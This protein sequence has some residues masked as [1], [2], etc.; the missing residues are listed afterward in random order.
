M[1]RQLVVLRLQGDGEQW[2]QVFLALLGCVSMYLTHVSD[3]AVLCGK[4]RSRSCN[5][6]AIFSV[7]TG[8][9]NPKSWAVYRI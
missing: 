9:I 6:H 8:A 1:Y 4:C 5:S 2:F 3:E 7:V